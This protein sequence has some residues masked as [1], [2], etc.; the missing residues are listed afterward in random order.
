MSL[1]D[2]LNKCRNE[3]I[4][5]PANEFLFLERNDRYLCLDYDAAIYITENKL[6]EYQGVNF[7][8]MNWKK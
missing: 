8:P 7:M 3:I 4:R 2:K 1:E 5:S 6:K